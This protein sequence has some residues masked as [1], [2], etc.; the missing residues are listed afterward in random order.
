MG[1]SDLALRILAL[2]NSGAQLEKKRTQ[3]RW[4]H[5]LISEPLLLR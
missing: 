3:K 1:W 2:E 5:F 4:I